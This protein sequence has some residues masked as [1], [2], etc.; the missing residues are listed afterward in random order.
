MP[1]AGLNRAAVVRAAAELVDH[2]GAEDLTLTALAQRLGVAPPSLYKHVSGIDD[3]RRGIAALALRDLGAQMGAAAVG[4]S[5]GDA[6]RG[7]AEA[8]RSY[9]MSHPGSYPATL[10]APD[11]D[12]P[13][14]VAAAQTVLDVVFAV[15][16]GYGLGGDD[17]IDATRIVHAAVHGF[18]SLEVAGSFGMDRDVDVTFDRLV[19]LLDVALSDAGRRQEA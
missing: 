3:V 16:A 12:D 1:R 7:M 15:L 14:D 9:A 17:A 10:R 5:R 2:E 4:R 11:S 18:V 19:S 6:L 8:Y 13:E